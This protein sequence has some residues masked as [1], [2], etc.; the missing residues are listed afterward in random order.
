MK[1]KRIGL[2][3]AE[4]NILAIWELSLKLPGGVIEAHDVTNLQ[5]VM[6]VSATS[7]MTLC[8]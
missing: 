4:D 2:D 8:C 7:S 3:P 5:R 6:I 1:M